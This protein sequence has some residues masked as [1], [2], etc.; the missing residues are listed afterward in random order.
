MSTFKNFTPQDYSITPF[1]AH[2]QYNFTSASAASNSI[3]VYS[4]SF[5]SESI[6]LFSSA[7]AIH[8]GDGINTTKYN[9][10]DNLFYRNFNKISSLSTGKKYLGQ[11]TINILKHK[12]VLYNKANI[13]SIPAGLYGHEIKPNSIFISSSLYEFKDDGYGNLML[14]NDNISN[15]ETDIRSNVLNIGPIKGFKKYDLNTYDGY[16]IDGVDQYFY[17]DGVKRVNQITSYTTPDSGIEYDDSYFYNPVFYKNSNFSEQTLF[18]GSF[19]SIDFNGTDSELKILHSE[20]FNFN[21]GDDF[22][23]MFWANVSHSAAE[24][25]YLISKSTTKEAISNNSFNLHNSASSPYNI[26]FETSAEP[27]FPYE[28]FTTGDTMFFRRS[29]GDITTTVSSTFSIGSMQHITCRYKNSQMEIFIN[30]IGSGVSG[31]DNII[32]QTQNTANIYIGNKGGSSKYLSGSLSQINIFSKAL[33]DTQI[34]NHYSSS[35]NSPYVGNVFY[36]NG[37]ITL[38]HPSYIDALDGTGD[39]IINTLQFQGSHLIYEHEYQCT[40]EEH[41]FN[42]TSNISAR[43]VKSITESEM[44]GFQSS[45]AFKPYVTTIGLYNKDNELLVVGK[46]ASPIKMSN[47]TDTTFVLRWDT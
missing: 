7:S 13:V 10:L 38:T 21:R 30:G 27:Q 40:I 45:S 25:S 11:D 37:F 33:S 36:Q 2:K 24:T 14:N 34:L 22:T 29:D 41:E 35:N 46:L 9:Q 17:L 28:I 18:R 6:S 39:G 8:G 4:S 19:P 31:S 26:P 12:R 3:R 16:A 5:T 43:K 23:I 42:N 44:A 32:N 1:N 15:Y 47:E 20:N